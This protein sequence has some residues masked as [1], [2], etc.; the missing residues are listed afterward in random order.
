MKDSAPAPRPIDSLSYNEA[1]DELEEILRLMQSDRC[2]IDSLAAYTSRAT[3][4]LAACRSRLTATEKELAE[5]LK[6]LQQAQS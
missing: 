3:E 1:L 2:D 5:I 4:L 6:P